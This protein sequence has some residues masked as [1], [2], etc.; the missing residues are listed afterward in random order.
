MSTNKD[1]ISLVKASLAQI[2]KLKKELLKQ[3]EPIA[4]IGMSCRF[5]AGAND[6]NA[7]WELLNRGGDGI[8]EV[9]ENR[10]DADSYYSPDPDAPGKMITKLG[11]FLNVDVR[12]FDNEFFG[13]SPKEAEYMDPQQRLLLEVSYEAIESAGI[14]PS[15]LNGSLTGVFI[16]VCGHDYMDLIMATGNKALINPYMA[17]G[18]AANAGVGRL[19]FFFGFQGPNFAIDTAC[20]S[21]LVAIDEA[22]KSLHTKDADLALAGGVNLIL[23]PDLSINF[24]KA[25][26]LAAD[27]H[28][29]TFD[30]SANGYARGEGC[31][32]VVLKRLSDAIRDGDNVLGVIRGSGVN[33][34]G[35]S[36]GLTVPNGNAQEILIRSVLE[37]AKLSGNQIDYVEAHGTGTS[38]GDPIEVRAIGAT[39]GEREASQPLKIASAKTNIGHLEGA[40]GIAGVIKT[41]LAIQHESLPP[42]LH[43]H[44]INPHI[45]LNFPV[46]ILTKSVAWERTERIRR[47]AVSSFGFSG[48][49]SHVIL[50]EAPLVEANTVSVADRPLH[51]LTLSAKN[52][53]AL[54]ELVNRYVKFLD[55]T[56]CTI[57]DICYSANT[58]RDHYRFRVAIVASDISDLK[59]KLMNGAFTS[60]GEGKELKKYEFNLLEDWSLLLNDLAIAYAKGAVIDWGKLYAAS[61]RK[62]VLL[63]FYPFQRTRFWLDEVT[64]GATTRM[65]AVH[66]LLGEMHSNPNQDIFFMGEMQ[67]TNLPYL[68]DHQ[69]FGYTIFPGAGHMELMLAA[70]VNSLGKQTIQL[71]NVSF[72]SPL[73]FPRGKPVPTQI[74]MVETEK[75]YEV[76]IYSM[77]E[78]LT[79]TFHAKGIVKA[80]VQLPPDINLS[81][82]WPR[83][84]TP[85][86]TNKLYQRLDK[87]GLHLG[88][89]FQTL[90]TIFTG[91]HE[92]IAELKLS[93]SAKGYSAHPA[94]LDGCLQ[95]GLALK[96][97]NSSDLYLPIGCDVM[98]LYAPLDEYVIAHWQEVEV[99]EIGETG[100]LTICSQEGQ[101]LATLQGIHFRKTT[102]RSLKQMVSHE[103]G[104]DDYF[105]EWNWQEHLIEP[106]SPTVNPGHWLIVGDNPTALALSSLIETKGGSSRCIATDKIPSSQDEFIK[107]LQEEDFVGVLHA[108]SA[109]YL[110]LLNRETLHQSQKIGPESYLHLCQAVVKI[111]EKISLPIFLISSDD[112]VYGTLSGLFKSIVDEHPDLK[113]KYCKLDKKTEPSLVIETLFANDNETLFQLKDNKC[114]V[115]RF[116]KMPHEPELQIASKI[117]SDATYLIT[118][119]LGGLGLGLAKWLMERNAGKIILIGRRECDEQAKKAL[120]QLDSSGQHVFYEKVDVSD[121]RVMERFLG[122]LQTEGQPLKGVFHLAGVLHD[123]TLMEQSWEQFS[124]VYAPK[125]FGSLNLHR[126][127]K[128]LDLFVMFSSIASVLGSPGQSNY[129]SANSFLDALCEYRVQHGLPGLCVSWGPW[130]D[131]GMAKAL[132]SRLAK[133]GVLA[134]SPVDG[135]RALEVALQSGKPT[136]TIAHFN[137]NNYLNHLIE[138]PVWLEKFATQKLS[139]ESLLSKLALVPSGERLSILKKYISDAVRAVLGL[140]AHQLIDEKKGFFDMGMDSLMAVELKNRLQVGIGKSGALSATA[141]FDHSSLSKMTEYLARFLKIETIKSRAA[142][143][144]LAPLQ[145]NEPIAIIGLGCRF[146]GGAN[147]PEAFWDLLSRGGDGISEIPQDRWD[148][149]EFYDPNP[150]TPGK[151]ITKLGG[152]LNVDVRAFDAE[153]FGISPKE[154]EYLD[155]QQRLLLEVSYEALESAGISSNSLDGSATSVLIGLCSHDYLDLITESGNKN[156]ITPYFATGNAASTAT[157]RVSYFFGLQ[158]PNFAID[159]ACSSSL[160]A[161][162]QACQSLQRGDAHMAL[163]GGVN[164]IL[165]PNL[166]I[167]FS[168]AGMLAVDGHCKTFDA[169]ADGYVRG[170]GCGIVVL[171]RLSDAKRDGDH[172]LAVIKACGVNQ[173]G[174]SS[175]LTVPNG[176]AQE[177]LIRSVLEKAQLKGADID[178]VEA[179]GTGTALG[180][181]VEV[182]AIGVT[183]GQRDAAHPLKLGSVKT[184]IGHLEGAA[185]IAGIIKTVLALQHEAIPPHLHFKK[186]NPH[187]EMNFPGEIV[188]L[189]Q[190]WKHGDRLRRAAVSSF[191]FSGTN[192]HIILEEAPVIEP[193]VSEQMDRPLHILTLSAKSPAALNAL[194]ASYQVFLDETDLNLADICYTANTGRNHEHYRVAIVAKNIAEL[195][196]KLQTN[197]YLKGEIIEALPFDFTVGDDS[198][199]LLSELTGA[200]VNGAII[201]WHKFD[202][203]FSRKKVILPLYPFQRTQFWL[204]AA[205]SQSRKHSSD[206]HHLL[207][208]MY[209]SP[210]NEIFY[211][212]ELQLSRLPYLR[213]HQ[214]FDD[215]IYP[216]AGHVEILLAA[217]VYGLNSTAI[218]LANVSFEAPLRFAGNQP[219]STQVLMTP[220]E[221]GYEVSIYSKKKDLAWTAHAKGTVSA[222]DQNQMLASIELDAIE[223]RCK[224]KVD[225]KNLYQ[226][227]AHNGLHLGKAFQGM[228]TVFIGDHEALGE[229]KLSVSAKTYFAHP[230]LLDSC[231]QVGMAL[232]EEGFSEL[233]IP[234]G[235]DAIEFYAPLG[236]RVFVHCQELARTEIGVSSN[237]TICNPEGQVLATLKGMHF[238]KTTEQS[239]KQMLRHEGG[240]DDYF[241][242]WN[243]QE[244]LIEPTSPSVNPGHWLIVGDNPTAIT[245]SRLIETKGGSSR[246]IPTDKIPSSQDEFIKLLQEEDFAGVLHAASA[247]HRDLLNRETLHQSQMIGPESYLHLCQAVVKVQ[248]KISLP[249]FLISSD[250]PVYG[251]LSGLFKSIVDEHPD[252]KLK[253]CK[254]DKKTEPSLVIE[255]LFANDNETFFQ[256]KDNKCYVPRFS[257]MPHEPELQITSKI[258]SDATYLITGGLGGL[259]LTLAKWLMERNAGRIILIGRRE[260]DEQAKKALAQL[261]S[262]GQHILYEKVDVSDERAM[263]TF[264]GRLQTERQPLKGIFHLAGVLH[265]GTLMEQNWA[266]FSE[267]YAPKVFG[268]LNLHH[269]TKDLDLFVMF[270][271][272]ASVLGSPG[273]SNYASANSFM[274]ALCEYRVQHGLPGLCV[275]WGPW[276]DVGMAKALTSRL[277]KDG[278][279]ALSPTNALRSLEVAMQ[280]GKPTITIAHFNWNNYLNHLIEPPVWLENFAIQKI[281]KESLLGRLEQVPSDERL[282][283]LKTYVS[284]AVRA[285]LGLPVHQL[286]EEKKGF[287]DMGMDSLMA[288]EL[289]NRLQV[290]LGKSGVISTTA[291]FDYANVSKMTEYLAQFLKVETIKSRVVQTRL[292][293]GQAG[294]PIAII[295][296]GCRF[297]GTADSPEAFWEMLEQGQEGISEIPANRWDANA[298]YDPDPAVPGKMSTKSG[299]FIGSDVYQFDASFFHINPREAEYLDPQQRLLLEV[300]NEAFESAGIPSG[301]LDGSDT[302]VHIGI[303]SHDY[304]ELIT[305]S[306]HKELITPYLAT[307]NSSSTA[308]GRISYFF[309]LQGSSFAVDTAC[310]SSLVAIDQ[311]CQNLQHGEIDLA[312]AGGVNLILSP[313]LTID[314]TKAG[315]LA[316]DGH[317]KTFD[318][319]ADGYVRGE[320]CGIVVLKRLQDALRDGN[321]ILAVIKASGV[322]QDGAK[323]GLTVPNG[324]AQATLIHRV[325]AKAKLNSDDIDYL[326]AH[327]TGTA[328]GD[329]I[330]ARAI[331]A[332][333]GQ[334][335]STHPLRVGSVKTNVGHLEGAAGVAGLIKVILSLQ[336]ETIPPHLHFKNLNPLIAPEFAA[337]VA[338]KNEKWPRSGARKRRAALSSF[339]FSGTNAHL[340]IEEAPLMNQNDSKESHPINWLTLS[341]KSPEALQAL[342]VRYV[343]YLKNTNNT[344]ADI[345]FTANVGR[346]QDNFRLAVFAEDNQDLSFKLAHH[347]YLQGEVDANQS[348]QTWIVEQENMTAAAERFVLGTML[349]WQPLYANRK[350]K[351]VTVPTYPF[352]RK[353]HRLVIPATVPAKPIL[354]CELDSKQT[355]QMLTAVRQ[356]NLPVEKV[357]AL[358]L[359]TSV[360]QP[361]TGITP[362][363]QQIVGLLTAIQHRKVEVDRII[364]LLRID[365]VKSIARA[366]HHD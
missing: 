176:E 56:S 317:C 198:Q 257:K 166:S 151:M 48:T 331:G 82:I 219:V 85:V 102:E 75:G 186:L 304:H 137:W 45:E 208:E 212:G 130:S 205:T 299:G 297:P 296:M 149:D 146:P 350:Y 241:Y 340:I 36:G 271:S 25:G 276:S 11:G 78:S 333:Y 174:A 43:F 12:L 116:S 158:G 127:T 21:S 121:E 165:S 123:G 115:P 339:G 99:T 136:I 361:S 114:Y 188:S 360:A 210:D 27:G 279:L 294:E 252:L 247:L 91:D 104:I 88:T 290:G 14:A 315:M 269:Y 273:Q 57:E 313:N 159:T 38:L 50:E 311:A 191:G 349:D 118:G 334:R 211:M 308:T 67:L 144:H 80:S 190:P 46:E 129:A 253:Y 22:C 193:I 293:P 192:A 54:N 259:G 140:A 7:Y 366:N 163:A 214:V 291:A 224:T 35:A 265:D 183:Y 168:K 202:A 4:I 213:D 161:L 101:V 113:L 229:V 220:T 19:S 348:S 180:D 223:T 284:E 324:E 260:C 344:L 358:M 44:K 162:D 157:G 264:L 325:L 72:E 319:S 32:I 316:A 337:E 236:E 187:I 55:T 306:G 51:L 65:N 364:S 355:L 138:P 194:I 31:G 153:F 17:T 90:N 283:I 255:T 234:I 15:S 24:S 287:F 328:L 100:N 26:M 345:C 106:T 354:T 250:D 330:E 61:S 200:Y 103:T 233:Y 278:V 10:W 160:V 95:L 295:G 18:N 76:N 41:I 226:R 141:A 154:A 6:P 263:E 124:E 282:P 68:K 145:V 292:T 84:K 197:D 327:G 96:A 365:E 74:L 175:G 232:R 309:G 305:E 156:L 34:G 143:T 8:I 69:V 73:S 20:S 59:M 289:K 16:G 207:G 164:L 135:L 310:S 359:K 312:V 302:G 314:F 352:Q 142:A 231:F 235:C 215:L 288:V 122:G 117:S 40:A 356:G 239:L 30:A 131:V 261:D 147:N 9:P 322:N 71:S 63:P 221:G 206:L 81:A 332:T 216:G 181:P 182:R 258:S 256:L 268:S 323:S 222:R 119:G 39:Y 301:S 267:A 155:P 111:Q 49:N 266:Q 185:G 357:L 53:A 62:K 83:C 23:S 58:G 240:S 148:A 347:Q 249:V 307:G 227:L 342:V 270:S 338:L 89:C 120:A 286:L 109:L 94:L 3:S 105:Y 139:K 346:N 2:Q 150:E 238:R 218:K 152:F 272:I 110:D 228:D 132:T 285:V 248:E 98:E 179:H 97:E 335:S 351:I 362:S 52:E 246:N 303:C 189:I 280:S 1:E 341:A 204:D 170:E 77:K 242:E 318:S 126:Y 70:G 329:P 245:L 201:D 28:C 178:Y 275:S 13:I 173:D 343:D 29:K 87:N 92:A 171:K 243:W 47:A 79:W 128:D 262:S 64:P 336:H 86:D 244:H 108:A 199:K 353:L 66:P 42:H 326:E 133:D 320:G 195:K 217:G 60:R 230:A 277:A 107:L 237:L 321:Q 172:I 134:L 177:A 169:G 196:I 225:V 363:P 254:L 37:K 5:P 274:D 112:P 251:T 93:V 281:S 298:Y 167:D 184:N 203:A 125:V 209:S 33:Q 300:T